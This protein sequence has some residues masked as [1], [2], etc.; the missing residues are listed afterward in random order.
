[1]GLVPIDSFHLSEQIADVIGFDV[2]ALD[3]LWPSRHSPSSSYSKN[4]SR[5]Y[6]AA[7]KLLV[8]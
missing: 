5:R 6:D 2:D 8:V 1:M 4:P 3:P 7:D